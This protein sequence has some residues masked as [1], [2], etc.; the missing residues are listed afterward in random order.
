MRII[1]IS[2]THSL[3]RKMTK[4]LPEGDLLIHAGD[5][6]NNGSIEDVIDFSNW[7]K[8]LPYQY[9]VIIAGN[10]DFCFDPNSPRLN[11]NPEVAKIL[12]DAGW[13]YLFDSSCKINKIKIY[14]SPYQPWFYNWAFNKQRG[15]DIKLIWDKIPEKIDVLITHGPPYKILD[16][17]ATGQFVGC[18]DLLA[19]VNKIKPKIHIFGHIHEAYGTF[20]TKYTKFVNASICTLQYKPT[21]LPVIIDL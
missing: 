11:Y 13:N 1:A 18:E 15:T 7:S 2:D 10:H 16:Q 3:H 19:K 17:T 12:I 5:I 20:E 21:N 6:T 8:N 14:G 9:K 4:K